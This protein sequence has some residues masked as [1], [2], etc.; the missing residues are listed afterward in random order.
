MKLLENYNT[1]IIQEGTDL[2]MITKHI[3]NTYMLITN[4]HI[5]TITH[6]IRNTNTYTH[7]FLYLLAVIVVINFIKKKNKLIYK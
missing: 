5:Y 2:S 6:Q 1:L 3:N 4:T 7:I